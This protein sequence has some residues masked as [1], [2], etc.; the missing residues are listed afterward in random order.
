MSGQPKDAFVASFY[1]FQIANIPD[2]DKLLLPEAIFPFFERILHTILGKLFPEIIKTNSN[3]S[4]G[5][6]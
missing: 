6:L 1:D 3:E 5:F 4:E 2:C